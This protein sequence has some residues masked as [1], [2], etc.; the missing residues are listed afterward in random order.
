MSGPGKLVSQSQEI[1]DSSR[2]GLEWYWG[3]ALAFVSLVHKLG[4]HYARWQR[5]RYRRAINKLANAH[6]TTKRLAFFAN[7]R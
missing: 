1:S 4:P 2:F 5:K 6:A 7:P 3:T